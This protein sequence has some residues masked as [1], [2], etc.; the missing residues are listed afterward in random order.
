M[1]SY[2]EPPGRG[3][4]SENEHGPLSTT[5]LD[6]RNPMGPVVC[7][8]RP[9]D[10]CRAHDLVRRS[11]AP[12]LARSASRDLSPP[13]TRCFADRGRSV[14]L[15]LGAECPHDV[16]SRLHGRE[17]IRVKHE[18]PAVPDDHIGVAARV[19]QLLALDAGAFAL[20]ENRK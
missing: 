19:A 13:D 20:L 3:R 9:P 11:R 4:M 1:G 5:Q 18:I 6:R 7:P 8:T 10:R 17:V 2:V 14:L 16:G 15:L 12:Q